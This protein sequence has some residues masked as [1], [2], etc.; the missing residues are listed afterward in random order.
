M[1]YEEYEVYL[2]EINRQQ[3]EELA[4]NYA[5]YDKAR[6]ALLKRYEDANPVLGAGGES[7][8]ECGMIFVDTNTGKEVDP[9]G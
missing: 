9:I 5:F 4:K 7:E 8:F 2:A 1:T 6:Q 3:Q